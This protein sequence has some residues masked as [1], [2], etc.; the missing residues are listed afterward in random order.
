MSHKETYAEYT[1]AFPL[2]VETI[3]TL[4]ALDEGDK[5]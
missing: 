2:M 3:T 1:Q 5:E 4:A